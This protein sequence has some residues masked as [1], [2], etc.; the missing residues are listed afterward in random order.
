[1]VRSVAFFPG[2]RKV[3]E[4]SSFTT[5]VNLTDVQICRTIENP[6]ANVVI[7]SIIDVFRHRAGQFLDGCLRTGQF[8][9]SNFCLAKSTFLALWPRGQYQV[10]FKFSD[11]NIYNLTFTSTVFG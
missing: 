11:E 5:I 8:R 3:I 4:V 10:S 9:V 6:P 1:M 7:Q 2:Q